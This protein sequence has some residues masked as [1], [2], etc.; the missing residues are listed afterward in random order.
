MNFKA[1]HASL[2]QSKPPAGLSDA[3]TALWL[4]ANGQWE[5]AHECIRDNSDRPSA[6][7]HA[8][9]H[10]VEGVLWNADYWYG[11]A[12]KQRPTCSTQEE[13]QQIVQA[14]LD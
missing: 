4:D 12:G 2:N 5:Q 13:W 6:W 3:L 10:H 14:L 9:L 7:V 1:F 8:Y 11:R